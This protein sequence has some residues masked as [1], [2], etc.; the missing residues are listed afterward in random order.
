MSVH[1]CKSSF[2]TLISLNHSLHCA[3]TLSQPIQVLIS[4]SRCNLEFW[5]EDRIRYAVRRRF[6]ICYS[7]DF[8]FL[9]Y[10]TVLK[11]VDAMHAYSRY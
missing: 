3:V 7:T 2:T 11:S 6:N 5:S 8:V 9:N 4:G 1:K 10:T